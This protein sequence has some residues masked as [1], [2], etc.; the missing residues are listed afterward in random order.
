MHATGML[1]PCLRSQPMLLLVGI[2]ER[3]RTS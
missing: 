3:E 2:D 1:E